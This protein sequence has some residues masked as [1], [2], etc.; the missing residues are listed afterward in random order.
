MYQKSQTY[1]VVSGKYSSSG[2]AVGHKVVIATAVT[3][4]PRFSRR[5]SPLHCTTSG[6]SVRV[7]ISLLLLLNG[8]LLR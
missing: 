7:Y 6:L 4:L 8:L 2:I 3:V 1:S 5:I